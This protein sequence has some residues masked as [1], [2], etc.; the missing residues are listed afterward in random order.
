M[1]GPVF[2]GMR[3]PKFL[4]LM[5]TMT[6]LINTGH[7]QG[8][9]LSPHRSMA[10]RRQ[11]AIAAAA[12]QTHLPTDALRAILEIEGGR[13]GSRSANTNGTYDLGPA[14]VNTINLPY[15]AQHHLTV[16]DI[17]NTWRGNLL[18]EALLLRRAIRQGGCLWNGLGLYHSA[19]KPLMIAYATK[20]WAIIHRPL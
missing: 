8:K 14:Q 12:S 4:S 3:A 10:A 20:A 5:A 9:T 2:H 19:T 17:Q 16:Y 6:V 15:L 13:L 18:A 1:S 11:S 7:A